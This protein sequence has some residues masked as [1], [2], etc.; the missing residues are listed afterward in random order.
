MDEAIGFIGLGLLGGAMAHKLMDSG[1]T[2]IGYDRVAG[3][4]EAMAGDRF[5]AATNPR[6]IANQCQTIHL[7]VTDSDAVNTVVRG[8]DGLL[9][10][11]KST[12]CVVV[13]HSTTDVELTRELGRALNKVGATLIDAPVSGGPPAASAGTLSIMAGGPENSIESIRAHVEVLG[14]FTRMG[15]TGAGQATKLVNQALVLPAYC[16]M[17]EALRLAQAYD[18]DTDKVPE[19][20]SNGHAGSNLL[21]VLFERMSTENFTPTGYARQVLKD[22]E[23]LHAASRD[24]KVAMPMTDQALSLFRMLVSRGD[25]EKDGA[26]IVSLWPRPDG[27][28][29]GANP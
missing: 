22:L 10:T 21:P 5:H 23:M 29:P 16:M 1:R 25:G 15:D 19:A 7:C 27:S 28:K 3:R 14:Q 12:Q 13:D 17:A 9:S 11:E 4:L 6:D 26:A 8:D 20:L 2:V 24:Q 18:V